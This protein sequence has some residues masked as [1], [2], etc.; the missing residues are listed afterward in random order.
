V[1][2]RR[3]AAAIVAGA[4]I[5]LA[6]LVGLPALSGQR[7][8]GQPSSGIV[9]QTDASLPARG[10]ILLGSTGDGQ[11][12]GI[13]HS[14]SSSWGVVHYAPGSGWSLEG[15]LDA[16]GQPLS[17]FAPAESPLAGE[18]AGGGAGALLGRVT[19]PEAEHGVETLLVRSAGQ[20]FEEV[21]AVPAALLKSEE[22]LLS[23]ARAPLLAALD[24]GGGS[25]GALVAPFNSGSSG[26]SENGVLHWNGHE[27]T[28]EEIE[29]PGATKTGFRVL[30]LAAS[31]PTN[32]WLVGEL[33]TGGAGLFH[34]EKAVWKPVAL[35]PGGTPGEVLSVGGAPFVVAGEGQPPATHTQVLTVSPQGLWIDG[36]RTDAH[37]GVTMFF[38]PEGG[39]QGQVSASWCNIPSGSSAPACTYTLP[40]SLPTG[41]YRSFAWEAPGTQ[42]GQRVITGLPE[43][44]SLRLEGSAFAR[45]LGLGS[46]EPALGAAFASPTEGWIGEPAL[47]VHLT[48]PNGAGANRLQR[49]PVPFRFA[50]LA[51]A[52]QPE[53]P[54]GSLSSQA[55]AVGDNGEVARYMPG[56]GWQPESLL[57]AGGRH[58]TPRLRAVAWP[59]PMRAYA[60]GELGEMW[61]WRGETGLWEADPAAPRN[62]RGDLLGV[63]F[64]PSNPQRGYAIGQQGVLLHY[65]KS[66]VQESGLPPEV[67][68]ASFT[69][70]AFAGSEAIVAFRVP[71]PQA[72]GESAHY[73]GGLL[74]N[75]GSGWHVDS[76]AASAL[77]PGESVPWAVA[78]LPDGGAALAGETRSDSRPVVLERNGPGQSW[79][80]TPQPYPGLSA[81]GALALFREGGAVRVV[82]SGTVPNTGKEDFFEPPPPAGFPENLVKPYPPTSGYVVRQT[83]SGWSDE[84]HDRNE[85]TPPLGN[86]ARYDLP[87]EPDPTAAVLLDPTGAMGW[88][89]GGTIEAAQG[90]ALDTADIARYPADGVPPPGVS[91]APVPGAGPGEALLAIGGD[92]ECAAPCS[93]RANDR[94]G[95]D[96]WLSYAISQTDQIPGVRDFLHVGPRIT[97]GQTLTGKVI[98][99]VPY[100]LEFGR[101]AALMAAGSVPDYPVAASPE[102]A[103]AAG[104]CLFQN[105]FPGVPFQ[106]PCSNQSSYYAFDSTGS[107]GGAVRVIVLDQATTVEAAELA[108]LKGQLADTAAKREPAIAVGSADLGAQVAA[109]ESAGTAVAQALAE[110][111]ASAYFYDSPE[112]N[113]QS[114]LHL[115]ARSL[116]TFG[117]GTLGY[118]LAQNAARPEFIGHSGFLL[119]QVNT[120][121]APNAEGRWPVGVRLI[122]NDGELALEAQ[123]GVLLRRSQPALFAGLARR[124]RSGCESEGGATRCQTSPYIP[125]PANCVG[126]ACSS[127]V[128]PEYTFSSSRTDIGNFV[129][130]NF[131]SPDPHA[132]LLSPTTGEP[133]ADGTSGLFCAFNAGTTVVTISAGGLSSSLTVTVQAGSVRRPCGTVPLKELPAQPTG[134]VAPPAPAPSPAPSGPAPVS[135]STPLVPVPVVAPPAAPPPT[136]PPAPAP[137]AQPVS[138]FFVP[139]AL[140]SPVPAFVPP[141]VPTPARPTPPTGTSAV[142][143]PVEVAEKEEEYEEAPESVSNQ[144]V[145][146]RAHEDETLPY[147]LLGLVVLAALAGA[148]IRARP[149]RGRRHAPVAP[150]T[151]STM[152]AQRRAERVSRRDVNRW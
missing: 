94:L 138:N 71:H 123:D 27:W 144:A 35:K 103:G 28:R 150:A 20:S 137:K 63:A 105:A 86:Y 83:P 120:A 19:A 76:S 23:Q 85:L 135:G 12:W 113:V 21:P 40:E 152:R 101:Y 69:S 95:P 48:S 16:Q 98:R 91:T 97:T 148:S 73:T 125:I 128:F 124:P 6:V 8:A 108:W 29:I 37:T 111:G 13:G 62:F 2:R 41:P 67:A 58:E 143:S 44:V 64:D 92:S 33:P 146:Y 88:A 147:Y 57:G 43:G 87:Y 9:V 75:S 32:A 70:I 74:V 129:K 55:L 52:P 90:G 132:V 26:V 151:V 49:Y 89:V 61:L 121:A 133:I 42:Y 79:Q 149:R 109:R 25:G 3:A 127:G 114:Q 4:V 122:P 82:G 130:R 24:E 117:T 54:I 30:A 136:V 5:C 66:W 96:S 140:V 119:A 38:K 59:T 118:V 112:R 100:G 142:T 7:A 65:G 104:E 80:P 116:P 15:M 11:T 102:I 47:P 31:S 93:N 72:G 56:E 51:V 84:E 145:A 39:E 81:P 45:Q 131:A 17:G 34:R 126:A 36:E 78:G 134:S 50:L 141:P 22:K 115:G 53:A 139:P 107:S 1:S 14:G 18:I 60:V 110:G 10:V 77:A 99:E 46:E 106:Q 68:G